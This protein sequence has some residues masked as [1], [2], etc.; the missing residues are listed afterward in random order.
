MTEEFI[1]EETK[2][3]FAG[4]VTG[5]LIPTQFIHSLSG[6]YINNAQNG[7]ILNNKCPFFSIHGNDIASKYWGSMMPNYMPDIL[8]F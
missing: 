1:L 7:M 3:I 4:D 6:G 2:L 8:V 5:E